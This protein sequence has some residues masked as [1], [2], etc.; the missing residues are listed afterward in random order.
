[1]ACL[2]NGCGGSCWK[3]NMFAGRLGNYFQQLK[4]AY[5][6]NNNNNNNKRGSCGGDCSTAQAMDSNDTTRP[7]DVSERIQWLRRY[8]QHVS[9]KSG[10]ECRKSSPRDYW[11][12]ANRGIIL[13][14][15]RA[16]GLHADV[17]SD[18]LY[19]LTMQNFAKVLNPR[20]SYCY[21]CHVPLCTFDACDFNCGIFDSE[22]NVRTPYQPESLLKLLSVLQLVLKGGKESEN[23]AHKCL[24]GD[25]KCPARKFG[26]RPTR[27]TQKIAD[28]SGIGPNSLARQNGLR[29]RF[30]RYERY[31]LDGNDPNAG[32][33]GAG[34][35]ALEAS[36]RRKHFDNMEGYIGY[37]KGSIAKATSGLYAGEK[38]IAYSERRDYLR[39]LLNRIKDRVG[40][41][42]NL[43]DLVV[44]LTGFDLNKARESE[45]S[46]TRGI[47]Q[48]IS[49][50]YNDMIK[51]D[52]SS[53][54]IAEEYHND[55]HCAELNSEAV[56]LRSETLLK[57]SEKT[58]FYNC[59][60][61]PI[62]AHKPFDPDRPETWMNPQPTVACMDEENNVGQRGIIHRYRCKSVDQR[63][64]KARKRIAIRS[65]Y[66]QTSDE[67]VK[68]K[69]RYKN[70]SYR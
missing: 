21:N 45:M 9:K 49:K 6:N 56:P 61:V 46:R 42:R 69:K 54:K 17:V 10:C 12:N 1:M 65:V 38:L 11:F 4:T 67:D 55:P 2:K 8:R 58:R 7:L 33:P 15:S 48:N 34:D 63:L 57:K 64:Q 44:A 22:G 41:E 40:I 47:A 36:T 25:A 62:L 28:R 3:K 24:F 5:N 39:K 20:N 31:Y 14:L 19:T 23:G 70:Q 26:L 29:R 60:Q 30:T 35:A 16:V 27:C 53:L 52:L 50:E 32:K 66:S 51:G 68:K 18:F 13:A 37:C 59:A 43:D